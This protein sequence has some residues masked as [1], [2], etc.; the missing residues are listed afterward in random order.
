M[1]LVVLESA[2]VTV[3]GLLAVHLMQDGSKGRGALQKNG[4]KT[5]K[6]LISSEKPK[7]VQFVKNVRKIRVIQ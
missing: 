7:L 3:E 6:K 5:T 1:N 2:S 4:N